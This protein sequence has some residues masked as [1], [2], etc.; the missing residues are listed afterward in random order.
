M[1]VNR[2]IILVSKICYDNI[3]DYG[4]LYVHLL[5]WLFEF[6]FIRFLCIYMNNDIQK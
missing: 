3:N 1:N 2:L 5:T 4:Q 6:E